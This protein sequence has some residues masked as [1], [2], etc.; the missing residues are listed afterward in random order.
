M[1]PR[2]QNDASLGRLDALRS[3]IAA[4]TVQAVDAIGDVRNMVALKQ[5]LGHHLATVQRVT[6][7]LCQHNRVGNTGLKHKMKAMPISEESWQNLSRLQHN[8]YSITHIMTSMQG[9]YH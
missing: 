5:Q 2:G 3:V 4:K 6:G 7:C 9:L 8:T 1:V